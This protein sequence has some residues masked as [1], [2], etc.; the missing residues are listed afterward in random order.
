MENC[1]RIINGKGFPCGH[2]R[3]ENCRAWKLGKIANRLEKTAPQMVYVQLLPARYFSAASHS[4]RK[5][6]VESLALILRD[7]NSL[8]VCSMPISGVMWRIS[9]PMPVLFAVEMIRDWDGVQPTRT[10]WRGWDLKESGE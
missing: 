6:G 8:W 4:A 9:T 3:C 7:G 5:Q 1:Y 2:W 10:T